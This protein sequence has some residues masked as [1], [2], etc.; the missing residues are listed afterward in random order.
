MTAPPHFIQVAD[1]PAAIGQGAGTLN[2]GCGQILVQGYDPRNFL[3]IDIQCGQCGQVTTTPSLPDDTAPPAVVVV[4]ERRGEPLPRPAE[5]AMHTAL[6]SQEEVARLAA[7]YG[8]RNPAADFCVITPE[9]L[10]AD[11]RA[12]DELTGGRFQ[13]DE[14][15]VAAA[16]M[17][18]YPLAWAIGLLRERCAVPGW[19]CTSDEETVAVS[20]LGA[21]RHFTGCW[22]HHPLYPRMAATAAAGGFSF[23]TLAPFGAAKSLADAG[24]RISFPM[25]PPAAGGRRSLSFNIATGPGNLIPVFVA[26]LDR[27]DWPREENWAYPALRGAVAEIVAAAQS[28]INRRNPGLLVISAGAT[29]G[30]F[31]EPLVTAIHEALAVEGRRNRGLVGVS[32]LLPRLGLSDKRELRFGWAFYPI[33]NRHH[34]ANTVVTPG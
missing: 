5:V 1:A 34:T 4:P 2:C 13:T 19:E 32:A 29:R 8:P 18:D 23:H 6:A 25:A 33:A 15:A 24:N 22:S 31:D 7:L 12:Y 17:K 9:T 28:L 14:T 21:F 11:I 26:P 10:A 3:S 27:F 16:G 30:S 20:V